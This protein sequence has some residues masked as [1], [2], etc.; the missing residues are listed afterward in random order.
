MT[1]LQ[2]LTV[3]EVAARLQVDPSTVY[4]LLQR[5]ELNHFRRGRIVRVSL[6]DLERWVHDNMSG[7]MPHLCRDTT[8]ITPRGRR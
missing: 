4:R 6:G 7:A 8:P 2:L 5:G 3:S 1:D